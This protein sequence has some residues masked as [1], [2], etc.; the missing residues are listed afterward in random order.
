MLTKICT[1]EQDK[2]QTDLQIFE[3]R[4]LKLELELGLGEKW[5]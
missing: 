5:A 3:K 2:S 4:V 1:S